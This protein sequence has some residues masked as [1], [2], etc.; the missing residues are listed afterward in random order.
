MMKMNGAHLYALMQDVGMNPHTL[1]KY[2]RMPVH[3]VRS[4]IEKDG[5]VS[6]K[7][8][9]AILELQDR[10]DKEADRVI[11][12]ARKGVVY[13]IPKSAYRNLPSEYY[14]RLASMILVERPDMSVAYIP[15]YGKAFAA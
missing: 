11:Q 4:E 8:A 3:V 14:A 10:Q 1:A 12:N 5:P 6:E 13:E 15:D 9:T 2:A 7:L